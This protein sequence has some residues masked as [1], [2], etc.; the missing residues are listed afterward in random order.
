MPMDRFLHHISQF[1]FKNGESSCTYISL[2]ACIRFLQTNTVEKCYMYNMHNELKSLIEEILLSGIAIDEGK[3]H[4]SCDETISSNPRLSSLLQIERFYIA[5]LKNDQTYKQLLR[6]MELI[7]RTSSPLS[8]SSSTTTVIT[9][10]IHSTNNAESRKVCCV[11]TKPP[12]TI[13]IAHVLNDHLP[14][15]FFIFDS[16][17]RGRISQLEQEGI[18]TVGGNKGPG[19]GA[20]FYFFKDIHTVERYLKRILPAQSAEDYG[21]FSNDYIGHAHAM[22]EAT[23]VS[24]KQQPTTPELQTISNPTPA[25]PQAQQPQKDQQQRA[26]VNLIQLQP[27]ELQPKPQCEQQQQH[28]SRFL[29]VTTTSSA[30][31]SAGCNNTPSARSTPTNTSSSP[32]VSPRCTPDPEKQRLM[33]EKEALRKQVQNLQLQLAGQIELSKN[34]KTTIEGLGLLL[35]QISEENKSLKMLLSEKGLQYN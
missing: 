22:F 11:L 24:V 18:F 6:E 14:F 10:G 25:Q 9:D 16:H 2:E 21:K 35:R 5:K 31:P 12:E 29:N 15:E 1:S 33:E 19:T 32:I 3:G 17:P 27:Q 7:A 4:R 20:G 8:P 26:D 13:C 34:Q 28:D 23:I 30:I